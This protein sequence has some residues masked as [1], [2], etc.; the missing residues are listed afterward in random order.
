MKEF[1]L[2]YMYGLMNDSFIFPPNSN[3][4]KLSKSTRFYPNQNVGL[5]WP[6]PSLKGIQLIFYSELTVNLTLKK[7]RTYGK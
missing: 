6:G 1:D 2:F 3:F 4:T 7:F 5:T